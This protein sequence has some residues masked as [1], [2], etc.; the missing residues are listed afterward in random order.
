[1]SK[2]RPSG[3]ISRKEY[4]RLKKLLRRATRYRDKVHRK[5]NHYQCRLCEIV[6][7]VAEQ[8]AFDAVVNDS[9]NPRELLKRL[10]IKVR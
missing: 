9:Y 3:T 1:M 5:Q 7:I 6:G 4:K 10:D 2:T 8:P